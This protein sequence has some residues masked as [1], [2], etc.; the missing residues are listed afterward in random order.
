MKT[1]ETTTMTAKKQ[2]ILKQPRALSSNPQMVFLRARIFLL[3]GFTFILPLLSRAEP[4][5]AADAR[6]RLAVPF[7]ETSPALQADPKE[8]IWQKAAII[9]RL[10]LAINPD[11]KGPEPLP[12]EVRLLWQAET[13]YVRFISVGPGFHVP[14]GN[15]H[16]AKHY[17][18]DVVE[19]FLD[20]VGDAR[21]LIELQ[22]NPE[23]GVLDLMFLATA[24]PQSGPYRMLTHEFLQRDWW[25][26]QEWNFKEL[27]VAN[28]RHPLPDG[29]TQWIADI[30]IPAKEILRRRGQEKL[31]PGE[32][33][34]N[35]LRYAGAV[36]PATGKRS[37]EL[38]MNWSPVR[39]GCPHLS[40]EALGTLVLEK[41]DPPK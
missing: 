29:S 16:D 4:E 30:A 39:H 34:A 8:E 14:Y 37:E 1:A 17:E 7:T 15:K 41:A 2:P 3:I 33:K 31:S 35:F 19:I 5:P 27:R 36:D 25:T 9:P 23:G 40:P 10:G 6:P 20:P 28:S 32:F 22:V 38:F 12:T 18:G 24:T 13:L 21:Q 26:R 11:K